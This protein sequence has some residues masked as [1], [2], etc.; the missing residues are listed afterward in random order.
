MMLDNGQL[1]FGWYLFPILLRVG[2]WVDLGGLLLLVRYRCG[3]SV[4]TDGP[5]VTS[6]IRPTSLLLRQIATLITV[7]VRLIL[8]S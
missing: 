1:T 8:L 4:L 6:L 5:D 2:G 3:I 7:I